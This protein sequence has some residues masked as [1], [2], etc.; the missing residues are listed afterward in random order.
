MMS[1]RLPRDPLDKI[2]AVQHLGI[3]C[4]KK[5]LVA[6]KLRREKIKPSKSLDLLG[7]FGAGDETRTH[8]LQHGKLSL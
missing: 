7:L 2:I 1:F 3:T 4:T 5:S 8:D 6:P